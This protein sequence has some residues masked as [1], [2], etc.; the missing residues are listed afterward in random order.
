MHC[1]S[2]AHFFAWVKIVSMFV[3]WKTLH[4][5]CESFK[6]S[7]AGISPDEVESFDEVCG[8]IHT[9]NS[10]KPVSKNQLLLIINLP[11]EQEVFN[12]HLIR[13]LLA[14]KNDPI[15]TMLDIDQEK[16]DEY[17]SAVERNGN[18]EVS[19]TYCVSSFDE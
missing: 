12:C 14:L 18:P 13:S 9:I 17:F 8:V 6:F 3:L 10:H 2:N 7:V 4:Y 15:L 5:M 1:Y 11:H 16:M 19:I